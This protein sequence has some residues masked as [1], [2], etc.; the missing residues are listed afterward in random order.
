MH[1]I[2]F[3]GRIVALLKDKIGKDAE[4]KHIVV[5]IALGPFIHVTAESLRLA[6]EMLSKKE[7][8]N[9][10]TLNIETAR[11]SIKCNKC[12]ATTKITGPVTACPECGCGDFEIENAEEF[13]IQSIE[14][15]VSQAGTSEGRLFIEEK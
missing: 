14:L 11:V 5:N 8:F 3:A 7:N 1:D 10:V 12:G 6:F 9:N 4:Q 13:A 15:S 2:M